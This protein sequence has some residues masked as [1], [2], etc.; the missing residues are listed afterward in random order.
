VPPEGGTPN[1]VSKQAPRAWPVAR[2]VPCV[3]SA[4][5]AH[6]SGRGLPHSKT[7]RR[8][9]ASR[10]ARQRLGVRQSPAAFCPA[11]N[12]LLIARRP[13]RA[14]SH[15]SPSY[16]LIPLWG[17][18][19][20]PQGSLRV[21]SGWLQG[22]FR[23]ATGWLPYGFKVAPGWLQG[24]RKRPFSSQ[25]PA[26]TLQGTQ[27][28]AQAT[29]SS[30][31]DPSYGRLPLLR[32]WP[33]AR[34]VPCV[35]S[36]CKARESGRGQPHSKTWRMFL[37]SPNARQRLGVRQSSAAFCRARRAPLTVRR[38]TRVTSQNAPSYG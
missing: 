1:P 31:S 16:G 28:H 2:A 22:G 23:V 6:E 12:E 4:S 35:L 32:L 15:T 18:C 10:N 5:R 38:P 19:R 8:F 17:A 36:V 27:N 29:I 33:V 20:E 37:A 11:R 34:A 24:G 26:S 9:L 7:W 13:T 3:L 14:T 21:A 25:V 30:P